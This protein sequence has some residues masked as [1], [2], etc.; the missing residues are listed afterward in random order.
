[1]MGLEIISDAKA[2]PRHVESYLNVFPDTFGP[3][4]VAPPVDVMTPGTDI[5]R[6]AFPNPAITSGVSPMFT[7]CI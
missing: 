2:S 1:M 4:K 6:P 3:T 5:E 7:D